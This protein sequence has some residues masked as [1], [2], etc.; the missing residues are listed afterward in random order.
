VWKF[1][2]PTAGETVKNSILFILAL[3]CAIGLSISFVQA[4]GTAFTYQG[5]LTDGNWPANG[6][7]DF[8]FRLASDPLANNYVGGAF[9][10]N[11]ISVTNGL[12][13]TTIDFGLGVFAG[14][15]LWLEI[16]VRTNGESSYSVLSP[17]QRITPVPF[18]LFA[19]TAASATA[20]TGPVSASQLNGS[21]PAASISG[22]LSPAQLPAGVVTNGESGVTLV[23][24]FSGSGSGLTGIPASAVTG[25]SSVAIAPPGMVLIPAGSYTIGNTIGDSDITDAKPIMTTVSAFYMDANLVSL[26]QW[27][28]VY[29]WGT[30]VGGYL[31][32]NVGSAKFAAVNQP[33]VTVN[34]YDSVKW[35]NARSEQA[36]L[37]P[38]Y[39]TDAA[40]KNVYRTGNGKVYANWGARGY[41]LPTEAEWEKAARGGLSGQR[42]PW[43]NTI[44]E[45]QANY[46]SSQG[47]YDFGPSGLNAIGMVGGSSPATSPVGSFAPNGYGLYDMAGN[48][49]QLCWDWYGT[50]YSGGVDPRGPVSG[51]FRMHRGGNW[52]YDASFARCAKRNG[53]APS[54]ASSIIGFR[55]VL[56]LGQ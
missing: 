46:S 35:C 33:V 7:Y 56:S 39:Y 25:L 31:F 54:Y 13:L 29:N 32:D 53:N 36:G 3:V 42:F 22:E 34:W 4:Q 2:K 41:R 14:M 47:G 20:V 9:Q 38:V 24:A 18:A 48:V 49:E 30:L 27:Q 45:R 10:T 16:N 51:S 44:S 52:Y 28:A 1:G 37:T 50:P 12:F 5:H 15:P 55:S 43:G 40:L 17:L 19:S 21:I 23:G 11:S 8:R 6:V 26:G